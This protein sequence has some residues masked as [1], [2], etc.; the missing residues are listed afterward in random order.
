MNHVEQGLDIFLGQ[1]G[2]V[3]RIGDLRDEA[4]VL[5]DG[6]RDP[7]AD[8]GRA[9]FQCLAQ[10]QLVGT[11]QVE[12]LAALERTALRRSGP[13]PGMARCPWPVLTNCLKRCARRGGTLKARTRTPAIGQV[14]PGRRH[15]AAQGDGPLVPGGMIDDRQT[16]STAPREVREGRSVRRHR[17]KTARVYCVK[18][19]VPSA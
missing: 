18:S 6:V 13:I 12:L 1:R 7:Q 8:P 5:A 10:N 4:L 19:L 11:D 3:S 14:L 15:I 16:S 17:G 9:C 2:L